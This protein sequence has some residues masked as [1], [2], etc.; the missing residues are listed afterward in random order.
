MGIE[1]EILNWIQTIHLPIIDKLMIA[2]TTL[3]NGGMLWICMT[4]VMIVI[5]RTRKVGITMAISL[6]IEV[7][8]CNL[9]LKPLVGRVRPYDVNTSIN[10]LVSPPGD[11]SFPSGHTGASFAAVSAMFFAGCRV[12]I[13]AGILAVLI[14]FSRLYL[15]IHYPT[16]VFAGAVIGILCGWAGNKLILFIYNKRCRSKSE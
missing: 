12:W 13:P 10:L 11:A 2:V 16:D 7:I 6:I 14:A 15:Y 5:P 4:L 1:L 8:C 9:I 3:G